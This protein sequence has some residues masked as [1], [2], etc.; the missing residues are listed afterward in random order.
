MTV[1]WRKDFELALKT[2]GALAVIWGV[3]KYFWEVDAASLR[4]AQEA[5]M[6]VVNMYDHDIAESVEDVEFFLNPIV[7]AK[8]GGQR[9]RFAASLEPEEVD[10][11]FS[12]YFL[13]ENWENAHPIAPKWL[14][15]LRYYEN[16]TLCVESGVCDADYLEKY[17]CRR[18]VR[19]SEVNTPFIVK[20]DLLFQP[21]GSSSDSIGFG[22]ASFVRQC[23]S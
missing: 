5:A 10:D 11:I 22:L 7:S 1:D 6:S 18:A 15:I 9:D 13:G 3:V 14:D 4:T 19:F 21:G 23:Q 2:I 8:V 17:L 16:A 12:T 20:Y